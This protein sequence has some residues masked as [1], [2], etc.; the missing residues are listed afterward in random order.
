MRD[1]GVLR[2]EPEGAVQR[3]HEPRE[4]SRGV[5]VR[6]P[7]LPVASEHPGLEGEQPF[8]DP[9]VVELAVRTSTQVFAHS[10]PE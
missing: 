3:G 4:S 2:Q 9:C 6:G 5:L 7:V 8:P 10:P 1:A